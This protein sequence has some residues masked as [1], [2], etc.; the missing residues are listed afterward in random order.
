MLAVVTAVSIRLNT[1]LTRQFSAVSPMVTGVHDDDTAGF[2]E[3]SRV[4]TVSA[5][6][7]ETR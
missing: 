1:C 2:E 4:R 5:S 7:W 6:D 3:E